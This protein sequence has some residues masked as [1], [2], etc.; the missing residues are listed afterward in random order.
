MFP[1]SGKA[2]NVLATNGAKAADPKTAEEE[3]SMEC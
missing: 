1:T 3:T 2:A